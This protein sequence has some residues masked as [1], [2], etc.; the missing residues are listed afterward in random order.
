M[1]NRTHQEH[2]IKGKDRLTSQQRD[3][4]IDG[5]K[6]VR[7]LEKRSSTSSPSY[8]NSPHH[9]HWIKRE[10]REKVH[11]ALKINDSSP[12]I[13]KLS[14]S[15]GKYD[16]DRGHID[17]AAPFESVKDAISKFGGIVDGEAQTILT[18]ERQKHIQLELEKTREEITKYRQQCEAAEVTKEH[19]LKELDHAKRLME[20]L[21]VRLEKA[22][23]QEAQAN[24][25]D[26][27]D[28]INRERSTTVVSGV[29]S[30]QQDLESMEGE[31]VAARKDQDLASASEEIEK[32]VEDLTLELIGTK[33]LLEDGAALALEQDKSNWERELKQ[34]EDE[35]QQLNEQLMLTNDLKSK[36]EQASLSLCSLRVERASHMEAKR[37]Q[38]AKD[39]TYTKELE[40]VRTNIEKA[41]SEINR[42]GA[43]VSSLK[44]EVE[45][46]RTSLT[47]IKQRE[48]IASS[49]ASSLAA[50]LNIL[51]KKVEE[52]TVELKTLE[53][54]AEEAKQAKLEAQMARKELRKAKEIAEQDKAEA[55][56]MEERL[57][58][59]VSEIKASKAV[60]KLA[61]STAKA[62]EDSEQASDRVTLSIEEYFKLRM[63]ADE[64]EEL[65]D[66]RRTVEER[67]RVAAE[68]VIA[69]RGKQEQERGANAVT[70]S[71]SELPN[72]DGIG[73]Q[74]TFTSE[75]EEVL[76]RSPVTVP[77]LHKMSRSKT[78]DS[79]T[80]SR[81]KKRS[82]FP[83]VASFLSREKVQPL[84]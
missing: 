45:M 61:Y 24:Q 18:I 64:A 34:A 13:S 66:G 84:K 1:D 72:L 37:S 76:H 58:A 8:L 17:T 71:F 14:E 63:K 75:T 28:E 11:E 53:Q 68:K 67:L 35:L 20:E 41:T 21:N 42:L 74:E 81:R 9:A 73:E 39:C 59:T 22:E 36:F 4:N 23:S 3:Q 5:P 65:D 30:E 69:W 40:E 29:D 82:F 56:K 80:D 19:V 15:I 49:S 52:K 31:H 10:K 46:E 57:N 38:V 60:E 27:L 6:A 48:G 51:E 33:E 83:R 2:C 77:K 7:V 12:K 62:M 16:I 43:A 79:K 54:A 25:E 50:E 55:T 32:T 44:S 26:E 47:I 78:M 70:R